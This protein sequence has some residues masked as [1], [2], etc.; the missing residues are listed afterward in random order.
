MNLDL[1]NDFKDPY[2]HTPQG[3]GA[4]LAGVLLGY[5]ALR[6]VKGDKN[7]LEEA[8]LFKQMQFGRLDARSLKRTLARVPKL[9]AAYR[10]DL[11]YTGLVNQLMGKTG[12][13]LSSGGSEDFGVEG[14]FAFSVG[15]TNAGRYFW[16]LFKTEENQKQGG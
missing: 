10:E 11:K 2:L 7:N 3:Q 6:Q 15:F 4:F 16:K 14:N 5:I 13:L 12:E 8:P 1:F 9:V